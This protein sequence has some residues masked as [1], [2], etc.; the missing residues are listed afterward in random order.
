MK[1]LDDLKEL[2]WMPIGDAKKY[3]LN[4]PTLALLKK[5]GYL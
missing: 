4:P 2:I 3:D 1:P 5:L